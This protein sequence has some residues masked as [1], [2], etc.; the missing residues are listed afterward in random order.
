MLAGAAVIV[1]DILRATTV[2]DALIAGSVDCIY[3]VDGFPAGIAL[4][5]KL[6]SATLIGE[7]GALPP[8][9]AN[10]GN[11]PTEFANADVRG[12]TVVHVTSNGT[13]A[14]LG[15]DQA[16][17]VLSGCLRNL[18]ASIEHTLDQNPERLAIVCSGDHGGTAPS[19]EDTFAAGAYVSAFRQRL[20]DLNLHGGARLALKLYEAYGRNP[21]AAFI[22]SPHADHLR[23]LQFDADLSFAAEIDASI[24]IAL[25]E[26]DNLGRPYL[27]S[28]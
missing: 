9:E 26:Q 11:S 21:R 4:R 19:I 27:H 15:A 1:L 14:L 10:H 13:R 6:A 3:P 7:I 12:W 22:D 24:S 2:H 28:A 23:K 16:A 5:A 18:S 17:H 25:L 20:P 8:P